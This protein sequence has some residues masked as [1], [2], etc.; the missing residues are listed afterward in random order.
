MIRTME[1]GRYEVLSENQNGAGTTNIRV[2]LA[3]GRSPL[4]SDIHTLK[5]I[6]LGDLGGTV[7]GPKRFGIGGKSWIWE[8]RRYDD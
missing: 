3:E 8:I 7:E 2:K 5:L 1:N 4:A 6:L